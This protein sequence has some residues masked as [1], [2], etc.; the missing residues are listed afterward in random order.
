M[1]ALKISGTKET[2]RAG[3]AAVKTMPM[4]RGQETLNE[5]FKKFGLTHANTGLTEADIIEDW[6]TLLIWTTEKGVKKDQLSKDESSVMLGVLYVAAERLVRHGGEDKP[7]AMMLTVNAAN[8]AFFAQNPARPTVLFELADRQCKK[9]E[10]NV[11]CREYVADIAG[12]IDALLTEK[13]EKTR[14][15]IA[16]AVSGLLKFARSALRTGKTG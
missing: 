9:F 15:K 2:V 13:D 1:T 12:G 7:F 3:A 6:T 14:V 5:M 11:D 10:E 8:R 16:I 4:I